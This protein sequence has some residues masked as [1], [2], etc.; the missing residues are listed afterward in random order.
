VVGPVAWV[1]LFTDDIAKAGQFYSELFGWSR[2]EMDM[3]PGGIYTLFKAGEQNIGGMIARKPDQPVTMWL[4]Y[5]GVED[6]DAKHRLAVMGGAREVVAPADIP[7]IGRFSILVDPQGA[8]FALF[9]PTPM[10]A[11]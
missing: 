1:E 7:S 5:F 11:A 3:G 2:S 10:P 4:T 8:A 6:V 9:K